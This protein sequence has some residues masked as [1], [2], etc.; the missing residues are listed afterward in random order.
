MA[1][2][3]E[4]NEDEGE[5]LNNHTEER[6]ENLFVTLDRNGDGK[7]DIHD[8]S[9]ALHE[10]GLHQQYAKVAHLLPVT[11]TFSNHLYVMYAKSVALR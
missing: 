1:A 6:L 9:V 8:L 10:A 5:H 7:I 4:E 2:G 3:I 11:K